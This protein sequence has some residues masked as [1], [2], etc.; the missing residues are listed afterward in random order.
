MDDE[1]ITTD[2]TEKKLLSSSLIAHHYLESGIV[3]SD[4]FVED[5]LGL[6]DKSVV[7]YI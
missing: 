7:Q 5:R 4:D 2:L 6:L 1:E 3:V